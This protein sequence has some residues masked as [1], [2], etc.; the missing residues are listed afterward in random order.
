MRTILPMKHMKCASIAQ[1]LVVAL[2]IALLLSL[3]ASAATLYWAGGSADIPDGTPLPTGSANLGGTWD[4]TTKNWATDPQ[5][6]TYVA[7]SNGV[8][9]VAWL[10]PFPEG[11]TTVT[12]TLAADV[13]LN[14]IVAPHDVGAK[15]SYSQAYS[16]T[17]DSPRTIALIGPAPEI[18]DSTGNITRHLQ[19]QENVKLVAA[20]GFAKTGAGSVYVFSESPEVVD[21]VTIQGSAANGL[22][23]GSTGALLGVDEFDV[24]G[25]LYPYMGS[26]ENDQIHDD[27]IVRLRGNGQLSPNGVAEAT[28]SIR[29]VVLTTS[30]TFDLSSGSGSPRGRLILTH[31]TAGIDRG[32]DG[33]GTLYFN[34][35]TNDDIF[36]TDIQVLNGVPADVLLPWAATLRSRPVQY[37]SA[38]QTF[39]PLETTAAPTDLASWTPGTRYRIE[40]SYVPS[41]ALPTLSVA[42][43]GIYN[44]NGGFTLAIGE[45]NTLTVASGQVSMMPASTGAKAISGGTL[46]SGTDEL[47]LLTGT[48]SSSG[49]LAISSVIAGDI[50]VVKGGNP[51]VDFIGDAVNTYTGTTYVNHGTLKLSR[52]PDQG[53]IPGD[54]VINAGGYVMVDNMSGVKQIN[55]NANVTIRGTLQ[56][57]NSVGQIYSGLVTFGGGTL[58]LGGYGNGAVFNRP[59]TGIVFADGGTLTQTYSGQGVPMNILTDVRYEASCTNPALFTSVNATA[60]KLTLT[61]TAAGPATRRFDVADAVGLDP[62]SPEMVIDLPL[63]CPG[64]NSGIVPVVLVKTGTGTLAFERLS[65]EFYGSAIVSNGTMLVNGPYASQTVQSATTT[66]Q[67]TT[68]SGLT[69][70]E[71]LYVSQP[72]SGPGIRQGTRIASITDA[73]SVKLTQYALASTEPR[74]FEACGAL[75]MADV[76]VAPG[77]TLGG[78]GG[79]GG[80][81]T[82]A[83][84]GVVNAGTPAAPVGT[85]AIGGALDLSVGTLKVDIADETSCD[86]VQVEGDLLLGGFVE[87]TLLDGFNPAVGEWTIATYSGEATGTLVAPARFK[88]VV[89]AG[90]QRVLLRK[91]AAGTIM[92][93]R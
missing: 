15:D 88:V 44:S 1:A 70:T 60:Q 6:T 9:A 40:G 26:G 75:G 10:T 24:S 36:K 76:T 93:V 47:Y 30:G 28:E 17:A 16:I 3:P 33:N 77:G 42:S 18:N 73:T 13:A 38:L 59:G 63:A 91:S 53:A 56:Q 14:Q 74:T 83:A 7:W 32:P 85:F 92:L 65:G 62:A 81:V 78:T 22:R 90:N 87:P 35:D 51:R 58:T 25:G 49:Y 31:P 19:F 12:I 29:Q 82:V 11:N 80:D 4:T 39:E 89:D 64:S 71:D 72:I 66:H 50:D 52:V 48:S 23:I 68:M 5:G 45:G 57:N 69:T 27:A 55:T 86:L 54:L 20:E 61:T 67:S 2:A 84:G 37:N 21:T 46:T 8:D 79:V 43:L 34:G 41:G